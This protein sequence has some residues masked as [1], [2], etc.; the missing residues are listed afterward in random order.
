V[1]CLHGNDLVRLTLYAQQQLDRDVVHLLK[2]IFVIHRDLVILSNNESLT[3]RQVHA[4]FPLVVLV[5]DCQLKV[6]LELLPVDVKTTLVGF[7]GYAV[8]AFAAEHCLT[9][10]H[11]IH[12]DIFEFYLQSSLVD[13]IEEN[14]VILGDLQSVVSLDVVDKPSACNLVVLLPSVFLRVWVHLKFEEQDI[15][16]ALHDHGLVVN[17][18]HLAQVL[19]RDSV[20][21]EVICLKAIFERN[22]K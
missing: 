11:E 5:A 10:P 6:V 15:S 22:D 2:V 20:E 1:A 13:K 9:A 14:A 8:L 12:H 16:G 21:I 17:Q 19:I 4:L 18:H 7:V 3:V